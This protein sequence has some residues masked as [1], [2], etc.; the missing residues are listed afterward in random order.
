MVTIANKWAEP[1]G[2]ERNARP[3]HYKIWSTK[4]KKVVDRFTHLMPNVYTFTNHHVLSIHDQ[5][6]AEAMAQLVQKACTYFFEPDGVYEPLL[7]VDGFSVSDDEIRTRINRLENGEN[8]REAIG[9]SARIE[10]PE[11]AKDWY[12][13]S[14]LPWDQ[15][16][17]LVEQIEKI[18]R[19][20]R[21]EI[22]GEATDADI[23]R[24]KYVS[25]D[26]SDEAEL[27]DFLD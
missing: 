15:Q 20:W 26:D 23:R 21:F 10:Y 27:P 2:V 19:D 16:R 5:E 24:L 9:Y 17:A 4:R 8:M 7:G 11:R 13:I 14:E 18:K 3:I 6:Y 25:D 12:K 1:D 22:V